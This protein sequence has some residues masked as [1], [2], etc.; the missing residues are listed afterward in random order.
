MYELN[1]LLKKY[2]YS[3]KADDA[4]YLLAETYD[5]KLRDKEKAMETYKKI[6][7]TFP[8]SIFIQESRKRYRQLRG[9]KISG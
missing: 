6:I 4:M 7:D 3:L 2:P 5:Y 1:L 8:Q 9:D